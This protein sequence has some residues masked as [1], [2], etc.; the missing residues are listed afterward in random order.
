MVSNVEIKVYIIYL[1]FISLYF[2]G[3]LAEFAVPSMEHYPASDLFGSGECHPDASQSE[4]A[5]Y[6]PNPRHASSYAPY[7]DGA[8]GDWENVIACSSEGSD[9][10]HI[11]GASDFKDYIYPYSSNYY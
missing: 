11:Q 10:Y 8:E 1:F 4:T 5:I 6:T 2:E 3:S 9:D 7:G